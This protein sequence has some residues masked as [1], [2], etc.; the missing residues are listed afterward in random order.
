ML[1][2][3]DMIQQSQKVVTQIRKRIKV[4]QNQQKFYAD[5]RRRELE[6]KVND[7]V[8][9][10]VSPSK[11]NIRFG[12]KGKL[13]LR[14]IGLFPILKRVGDVAYEL[15]LPPHLLAVHLVF[16]IS[17]LRYITDSSHIINF[18]EIQ[19]CPNLS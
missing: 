11:Q 7:L 8:F 6:F 9:L 2:G 4:V 14:Y 13:S 19:L 16:H 1:V 12:K 15:T 17:M 5:S 18:K 3:Q 10:T